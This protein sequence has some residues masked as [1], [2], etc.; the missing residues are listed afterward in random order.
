M[1][2]NT[3]ISMFEVVGSPFCVAS[4]DGQKVHKHLNAAL[5]ANQDVVLSFHN[6]ND[7]CQL[8]A[9]YFRFHRYLG[10]TQTQKRCTPFVCE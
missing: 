10:V 9:C 8:T 1:S 5:K 3:K 2:E 7:L 4:D 6:V